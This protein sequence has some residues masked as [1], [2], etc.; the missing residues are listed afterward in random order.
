M[1]R[2]N[3]GSSRA[4]TIHPHPKIFV[5]ESKSP[6][7]HTIYLRLW[8]LRDHIQAL[9]IS[10]KE[11]W[12][13]RKEPDQFPLLDKF[14]W[15]SIPASWISPL[16][17]YAPMTKE[18][19]RFGFRTMRMSRYSNSSVKVSFPLI[20]VPRGWILTKAIYRL[21]CKHQFQWES[22]QR[23]QPGSKFVVNQQ[24]AFAACFSRLEDGQ[25]QELCQA[26][27][28]PSLSKTAL[29]DFQKEFWKAFSCL[30]F[31]YQNVITQKARQANDV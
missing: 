28:T 3:Q 12:P 29:V 4:S 10:F 19:F 7:R 21:D 25:Y 8:K 5:L 14:S 27:N 9:M 17:F 2:E 31:I 18:D 1:A 20:S 6:R 30:F 16:S 11:S 23:I 13:R 26:L 24:I 15:L 22:S